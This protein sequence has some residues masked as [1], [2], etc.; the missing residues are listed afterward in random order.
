[1]V[2]RYL[3][4]Y[5]GLKYHMNDNGKFKSEWCEKEEQLFHEIISTLTDKDTEAQHR[6]SSTLW[7]VI[8]LGYWGKKMP[9]DDI[10]AERLMALKPF[11][12]Q[13]D[14]VETIN[15]YYKECSY[16]KAK[17]TISNP[18]VLDGL[19]KIR[20]LFE[21]S[22]DNIKVSFDGQPT[23]FIDIIIAIYKMKEEIKNW[24]NE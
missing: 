18:S 21:Q 10:K 24:K 4:L 1:M 14:Y 22:K 15:S 6:I 11:F 2:I 8:N 9:Y 20:T 5:D 16:V 3:D 19:N 23:A 12:S 17:T 7:R 13:D